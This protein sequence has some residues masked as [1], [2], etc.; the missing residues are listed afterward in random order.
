[1]MSP[2]SST[3]S[4]SSKLNSNGAAWNSKKP[5]TKPTAINATVMTRITDSSNTS[6]SLSS[7][8]ESTPN[9]TRITANNL[10]NLHPS[11]QTKT[12][13]KLPDLTHLPTYSS[14]AVTSPR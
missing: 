7:A 3:D 14:S 4:L 5:L 8:T 13:K 6:N 1:M 12:I 9:T 10:L 11:G 2:Y